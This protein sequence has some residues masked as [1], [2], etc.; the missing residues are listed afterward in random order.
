MLTHHVEAND[1]V[2]REN[3]A[4]EPGIESDR[5]SLSSG[6]KSVCFGWRKGSGCSYNSGYMSVSVAY[7]REEGTINYLN[8]MK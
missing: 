4:M 7:G 8:E 6:V 5:W 1:F 2:R 3:P